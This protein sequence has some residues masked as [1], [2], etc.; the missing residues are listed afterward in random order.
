MGWKTMISVTNERMQAGL[1]SE[2]VIPEVP[3][4]RSRRT[5]RLHPLAVYSIFVSLSLV[6][7]GS[8]A[9]ASLPI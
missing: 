4:L 1:Y 9:V 7:L 2:R 3:R 8:M 5:G 6:L